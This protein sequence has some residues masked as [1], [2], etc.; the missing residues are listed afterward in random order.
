M[1]SKKS[2][3]IHGGQTKARESIMEIIKWDFRVLIAGTER[4]KIENFVLDSTLCFC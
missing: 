4:E 1:F 3:T 2:V